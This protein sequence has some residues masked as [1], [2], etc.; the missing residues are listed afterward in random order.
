MEKQAVSLYEKLGGQA[1]VEAVVEEF[2]IREFWRM[3]AS[4]FFLT[5][6]I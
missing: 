6:P 2:F 3:T 5:R 1:A 4:I